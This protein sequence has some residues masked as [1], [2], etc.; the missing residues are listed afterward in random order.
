MNLHED[1]EVFLDLVQ[2][3]AQRAQLPEVYIE[4]DYWV[5][6]VLKNISESELADSLVFKGGTSLSKAHKI[7]ERFSEDIDLAIIDLSI[8]GN[9]KRRLLKEIEEVATKGLSVVKDDDRTSKASQFRKTVW[10]YPRQIVGQDFGQASKNLLI[11]VN[12]FVEPEPHCQMAL[13][14]IISEELS[15]SGK[16]EFIEHYS[17]EPFG[18]NVLA[19]ERTLV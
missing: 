15:R 3:T 14:S 18:L 8:S 5:T 19:L 4:K 1:K 10:Q 17:L 2:A 6:T 7:V 12:A 11:E 13:E 9:Q 16:T